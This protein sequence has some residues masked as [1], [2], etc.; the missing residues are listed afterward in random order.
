MF[1]SQVYR[2]SDTVFKHY[3]FLNAESKADF[4]EYI[5]H[6]KA[7]SL[8]DTGVTASY[9]DKLLTMVTCAYHTENGQFVVVA[10]C[11]GKLQ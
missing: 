1:E 6:I 11:D 7:L 8:Y 10:E 9:G 5:T 2:K 3:N 4:D